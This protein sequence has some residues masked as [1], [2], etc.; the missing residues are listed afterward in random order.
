MKR[1]TEHLIGMWEIKFSANV[2][3]YSHKLTATKG[4]HSVNIPCEDQPIP[5]SFVGIWLYDSEATEAE[6]AELLP[7]LLKWAN[8]MNINCNVYSDRD[9]F[10]S[11]VNGA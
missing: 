7:V 2:H 3:M 4:K 1:S 11:N 8:A 9:T 10:S 6:Q 5:G